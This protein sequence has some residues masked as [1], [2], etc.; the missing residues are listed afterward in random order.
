MYIDQIAPVLYSTPW[1]IPFDQRIAM[2]R[3]GSPRAAY[4]Y[5]TPDTSTFRYRAYNVAQSLAAL[6][7]GTGPSASWFTEADLDAMPRVL[8]SCDLLILCRNS[9][10]TDRVA[11]IAA[12]ARARHRR[13]LFDVDD[14]VFDQR[15]THLVMDTL[16]QNMSDETVWN[17]WFSYIGRVAATF[18]LCDG[19][20]VTNGYLSEFAI[21]YS[22]KPVRII[23][24]YLNRE[25]QDL[26]ARIW[27]VKHK[28]R[29]RRDGLVHIGYFSG[30][31]S[32]DR[33]F[34]VAAPA[35][36]RLMDRNPSV[37]L[38]IVGFLK[39]GANLARYSHRIETIP[40]QDFLNLQR[41]KGFVE[42][43]IVPLQENQFTNCKS[44]LKWFEAAIVG[45]LTIASPT[46]AYSQAIA[47]G[48]NGWLSHAGNWEHVLADVVD[49]LDELRPR[50]APRA[51]EEA[52]DR[53]GSGQQVADIAAALFESW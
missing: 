2:L 22:R 30:S 49:N 36:A 40:L 14:L 38:R 11:R 8:D 15:Y 43:N 52:L 21:N 20:I 29:W 28:T 27:N 51:R 13:I 5:S 53:Y 9:L 32:H 7:T 26:S 35:L 48:G 25:Q 47:H 50:I 33:D 41:E 6:Q 31:P 24:N 45:T 23:K 18:E 42:I 19:A 34:Q 44:D 16:N 39:L 37:R 3:R 17:Y 4:Y 10:Y 46:Y 1:D 12:M